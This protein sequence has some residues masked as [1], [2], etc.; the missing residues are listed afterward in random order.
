MLYSHDT[1]LS[2]LEMVTFIKLGVGGWAGVK[3]ANA[4]LYSLKLMHYIAKQL[5]QYDALLDF[6][7]DLPEYSSV[8]PIDILTTGYLLTNEDAKSEKIVGSTT[9]IVGI[10]RVV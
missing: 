10:L 1:M 6:D 7:F 4:A 9:A 3:G 8:Q 5:H 2:E